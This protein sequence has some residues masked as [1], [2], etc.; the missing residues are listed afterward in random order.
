MTQKT[1]EK[2][3][4]LALKTLELGAAGCHR[5][6]SMLYE[7]SQGLIL[8]TGFRSQPCVTGARAVPTSKT[9]RDVLATQESKRT[10]APDTEHVVILETRARETDSIQHHD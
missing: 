10:A 2:S 6:D 9:S 1:R 3:S 8:D 7:V 5:E 4:S